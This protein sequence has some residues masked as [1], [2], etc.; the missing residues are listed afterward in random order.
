MH[1]N[2]DA[3]RS[4]KIFWSVIFI[5]FSVILFNDEQVTFA[6]IIFLL[7]LLLLGYTYGIEFKF[8][9][10]SYRQYKSLFGKRFGQWHSLA[11]YE[12]QVIFK[13][14]GSRKL[15]GFR[16]NMSVSLKDVE[17]NLVFV[18][19]DHRK[20]LFVYQFNDSKS[21]NES[22]TYFTEKL[23][24]PLV[25]YNPPISE[26]TQKLRRKSRMK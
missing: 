21:V 13:V 17:Y 6:S 14:K 11:E 9:T 7:A 23:G 4:T 16:I 1:I 25:K 2:Q 22:C 24:L 3:F 10:K 18:K 19:A 20:Q 5:L 15:R 26:N 8:D 12:S